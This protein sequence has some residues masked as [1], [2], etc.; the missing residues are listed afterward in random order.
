MDFESFKPSQISLNLTLS[1]NKYIV[2]ISICISGSTG[3]FSLVRI[4][5]FYVL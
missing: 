5:R 1:A 4:A 2:P 3:E